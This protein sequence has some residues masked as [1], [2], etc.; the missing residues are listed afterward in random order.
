MEVPAGLISPK[1]SFLCVQVASLIHPF[2]CVF[3]FLVS[4]CVSN[5]LFLSGQQLDWTE[6]YHKRSHFNS[7][8]F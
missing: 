3:T 2:L 7:H 6:T 1:A 8:L 4:L 5:L